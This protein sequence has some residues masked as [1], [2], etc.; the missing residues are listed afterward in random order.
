MHVWG[1]PFKYFADV[2]QAAYEIGKFCR[3]WGR[4]SVTQTK[5]K[6]GTARVSASFGYLSL[7]RLIYPGYVYSQFPQW[8]WSLDIWYISRILQIRLISRPIVWYQTKIYRLAYK[9]ALAKYPHIYEEIL[10]GADWDEFLKGLLT[11]E[12]YEAKIESLTKDYSEYYDRYWA[13]R[14]R[15]RQILK[16]AKN[17]NRRI[18]PKV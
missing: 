9:R 15:M 12:H 18:L 7:H 17:L 3:R 13:S 10:C 8:L 5:E 4:I 6:Y 16:A 2:E 1:G 14:E 11:P